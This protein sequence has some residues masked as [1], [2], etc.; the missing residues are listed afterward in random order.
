[1]VKKYHKSLIE[2]TQNR[3]ETCAGSLRERFESNIRMIEKTVWEDEKDFTL[4]VP[5]NL[6]NDCVY[7][8]GKKLDIPDENLLSST[9]K[10]SK[11]VMVSAA[12]SWYGVTKPFFVNSNGIRVGKENYFPHL[13]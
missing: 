7:G 10:M 6:Q 11:K 9:S 3:R 12:I 1:M 13:R 8:K 5:V 4:E 2:G